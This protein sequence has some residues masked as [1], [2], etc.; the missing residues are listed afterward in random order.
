M[1]RFGRDISKWFKH[2]HQAE[3]FLTGLRYEM[4]KGVFDVRDYD[5]NKPLA[6]SNLAQK[7]LV[8]K[9]KTV[10][11]KSLNNLKNYMGRA[12]DTWGF[13]NV[14]T[15]AY[16]EIEDFLYA[17]DVSEKTRAN[18]KSCLHDFFT[19]LKRRRVITQQ[20]FPEFPEID[21]ELGWRNIIDIGTQQAIISEV[22]RISYHLNPKIWLAIKW[23][24]T[25]IGVRP[26]ELLA[27]KE[28][29]INRREGFLVFPNPKEKKPKIVFLLPEDRELL[30]EIPE[31]LPDLPFF[32][33]PAGVKGCKAGQ[34]FGNRYFYKWWKKACANLGV[35]GVDL[36]GGTR[37]STV[38]AL[39]DQLTPEQIKMGTLHS[40]NKAFERYF[41]GAARN[42]K[43]VYQAAQNLQHTYN[44]KTDNKS[45]NILKL[46]S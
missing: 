25:Y 39:G 7:Y 37:H 6:F 12:I 44:I 36:Y 27:L 42:A 13:A 21:F 35:H 32:R 46:K 3:R 18:I 24:A 5:K 30:Q 2:L 41:Q 9:A 8:Q 1:V 4:D 33:H 28:G 26:G 45:S 31:G 40:T 14:K 16:S 43:L 23:L 19:W 34:G 22:R 20:Q 17:Q 29:H 38:T 10:K 11:P 15:I